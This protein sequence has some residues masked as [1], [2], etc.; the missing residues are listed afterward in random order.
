VCWRY[1]S[2]EQARCA[3]GRRAAAYFDRHLHP[4]RLAEY[5]LVEAARLLDA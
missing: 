4:I 5:Y 3:V 2:D 1:V